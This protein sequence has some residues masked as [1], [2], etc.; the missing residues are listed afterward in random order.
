MMFVKAIYE[1][2]C[3]PSKIYWLVYSLTKDVNRT[4]L[5]LP[6]NNAGFMAWSEYKRNLIIQNRWKWCSQQS[7]LSDYKWTSKN[8]SYDRDIVVSDGRLKSKEG[9]R[10][11]TGD[12]WKMRNWWKRKEMW[13]IRFN[14]SRVS[15]CKP[16][17]QLKCEVSCKQSWG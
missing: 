1:M 8:L 17:E 13:M 9:E 5:Q 10:E 3:L 11:K 2:V 15:I 12:S 6:K 14:F 4:I 7:L 16:K